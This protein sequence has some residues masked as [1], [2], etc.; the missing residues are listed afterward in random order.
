MM[1]LTTAL[2]ASTLFALAAVA[3]SSRDDGPDGFFGA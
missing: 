3:M 2:V 1:L